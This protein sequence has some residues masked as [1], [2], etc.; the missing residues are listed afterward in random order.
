MTDDRKDVTI[1][2]IA[3]LAGVSPSTV[4]RV[5]NKSKPVTPAT[6]A[7]V[8]AAIDQLGFRPNLVAQG[9][10]RGRSTAIGVLIEELTSPFYGA[11]M[12]GIE[13]GL[14]DSGFYPIFASTHWRPGLAAPDRRALDMLLGRRVDGI[15]IVGSHVPDAVYRELARQLPL[16][17]VGE[18]IPGFEERCLVV[19][20]RHSADALTRHLIQ[21]GHRRIAHISGLLENADGRERLEGYQ[22]SMAEAGLPELVIDG[23]FTESSGILAVD[24][25]IHERAEFSA[26]FAANDQM[27]MGAALALHRHGRL[28]PRDVSLAGF[29]DLPLVRYSIPPLTTVR[30]PT[31]EMGLAAARGMLDLIGGRP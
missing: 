18:L 11:I 3:R 15:L 30:Q 2:D 21:L 17:I 24:R 20:N 14:G 26:I 9:L 31:H 19:D 22:R 4:S 27:A 23:D 6:E 12:R 25:L 13:D 7:A 8:Q 5:L 1:N 16:L 10:A 29:D 28:V